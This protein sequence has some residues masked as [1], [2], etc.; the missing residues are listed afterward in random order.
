[1]RSLRAAAVT[2]IAVGVAALVALVFSSALQGYEGVFLWAVGVPWVAGFFALLGW[3]RASAKL[4]WLLPAVPV[5]IGLVVW[6]MAEA[7]AGIS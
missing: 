7:V 4:A 6:V 3:P 2:H 1:M 5:Q